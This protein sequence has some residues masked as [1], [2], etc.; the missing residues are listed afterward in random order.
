[1]ADL[2]VALDLADA[3]AA[4]ALA[5]RLPGLRC[6]KLGPVLYVR[7]G[8][9]LVRE[10]AAR[11]VKVFLDLKWHDIPTTVAGAVTAARELGV[12]M[13]TVHCLGGRAML[14]A[15]AVAAGPDVALLGVTVLTSHDAAGF[16]A[17][18]GRGVP[19]L[20]FEAERLARPALQAGLRGVVASGHELGLL[21]E[22]LG[23][24]PWIVV[25][26]IRLPGDGTAD[27][28]RTMTPADAVRRGASHLVVGRSITGAQDPV[29]AYRRIV[30]ELG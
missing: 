2:I 30:A 15:A 6:V 25:P 11:G 28:A 27:Q 21:R 14:D 24:D 16:E 22:A 29:D 17:V 26:G 9:A 12:A 3:R 10:F 4:A 1:M 7:E 18:L 5:S 20:A 13:A 23:P 8:P 19:D